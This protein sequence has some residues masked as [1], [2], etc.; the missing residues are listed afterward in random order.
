MLMNQR[1]VCFCQPVASMIAS[2]VA[3]AFRWSIAVTSALYVPSRWMPESVFLPVTGLLFA[4][5]LAFVATFGLPVFLASAPGSAS[6]GGFLRDPN[7]EPANR[8]PDARGWR[9][10]GFS[11]LL[12]RFHNVLRITRVGF[13]HTC[14]V[15]AVESGVRRSRKGPI[16]LVVA[17]IFSGA[18][19]RS[20]TASK[21]FGADITHP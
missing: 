11:Y 7:P 21:A 6:T 8:D 1:T 19:P 3:P 5:G 13:E 12:R 2:S 18:P 16:F 10:H 20:C 9:G 17:T 15:G 4:A 14:F